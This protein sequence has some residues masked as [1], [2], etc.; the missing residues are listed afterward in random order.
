MPPDPV[1]SPRPGHRSLLA[2]L[3]A[4]AVLAGG[5]QALAPA[6]AAAMVNQPV[7]AGLPFPD[8]IFCELGQNGG[9]GGVAT[10]GSG[11]SANPDEED[12]WTPSDA[13]LSIDNEIDVHIRDINLGAC[14]E[15]LQR[16]NHIHDLQSQLRHAR[17]NGHYLKAMAIRERLGDPEDVQARLTFIGWAW[18]DVGCNDVYGG[19]G[20]D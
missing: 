6:S 10:A 11:D 20:Y 14:N 9:G 16:A 13:E 17:Q 2:A 3:A 8:V 5:A 15:L 12:G 4:T 19:G 1:D 18:E 7:C